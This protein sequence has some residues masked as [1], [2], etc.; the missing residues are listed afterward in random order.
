MYSTKIN[1]IEIN[2]KTVLKFIIFKRK[3]KISKLIED[4]ILCKEEL[5]E[6]IELILSC[7]TCLF[8]I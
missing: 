3:A 4:T 5:K 2:I 8:K 7:E 6:I 1:I